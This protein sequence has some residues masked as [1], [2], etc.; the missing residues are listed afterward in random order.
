MLIG[1]R[2]AA[3][4]MFIPVFRSEKVRLSQL[5]SSP[6]LELYLAFPG[7]VRRITQPQLNSQV[8]DLKA[9]LDVDQLTAT[10]VAGGVRLHAERGPGTVDCF[11]RLSRDTSAVL[12]EFVD[13]A[14]ANLQ[15]QT[16]CSLGER[17]IELQVRE[18]IRDAFDDVNDEIKE[19][20]I[21]AIADQ[22]GL[23]A[24]LVESVFDSLVTVTLEELKFPQVGS[25]R[26]IEIKPAFGVP[27]GLRTPA[28]ILPSGALAA[29]QA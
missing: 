29:L 14:I 24:S 26:A 17:A 22:Q 20:F 11:I 16:P 7:I 19:A 6:P 10:I 23:P 4:N 25:A 13:A 5:V 15:V 28:P 3:A 21:S 18:G 2:G 1:R 8:A 12:D 27:R 9:Q